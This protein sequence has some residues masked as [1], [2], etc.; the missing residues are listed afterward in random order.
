VDPEIREKGALHAGLGLGPKA[1]EE[2][3]LKSIG[4]FAVLSL[5]RAVQ[6]TSI[7]SS[8]PEVAEIF[9]DDLGIFDRLTRRLL[10]PY[11]Y[12]ELAMLILVCFAAAKLGGKKGFVTAIIGLPLAINWQYLIGLFQDYKLTLSVFDHMTF[13][14]FLSIYGF[15]ILLSYLVFFLIS[16]VYRRPDREKLD[17]S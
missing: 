10:H 4:M 15:D 7:M 1:W 9:G 2:I 12:I 8:N 11:T 3:A 5:F 14:S 6:V 17:S 13:G 16:W